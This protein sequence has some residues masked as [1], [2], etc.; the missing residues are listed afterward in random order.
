MG[1][2]TDGIVGI[3]KVGEKTATAWLHEVSIDDMPQVVLGKY[4][5]KFGTHEGV[6]RFAET[7]KLVYILKTKEEAFGETGTPIPNLQICEVEEFKVPENKDE[8]WE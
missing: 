2:S 6:N 4:I 3:P 1:D 7:F 8:L 5:E